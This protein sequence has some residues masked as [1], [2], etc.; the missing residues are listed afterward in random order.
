MSDVLVLIG[1]GQQAAYL[2]DQIHDMLDQGLL[3]HDHYF[4]REGMTEWRPLAEFPER[5]TR[6]VV[7][8]RRGE[9]PV[10]ESVTPA[11][12]TTMP[13]RNVTQQVGPVRYNAPTPVAEE[14]EPRY[15]LLLLRLAAIIID[16]A[17]AFGP[18]IFMILLM[19]VVLGGKITRDPANDTLISMI[20]LYWI[21]LLIV[22]PIMLAAKGQTI[23]KKVMGLRIVSARTG[24][25]A[26]FF[27]TV[28]VRTLTN[29]FFGLIPICLLFHWM[30]FS[31]L[32]WI[33]LY[34]IIDVLP[35]FY[36]DRCIHDYVAGT[37]VAR[38]RGY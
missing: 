10:R 23:G 21:G 33:C 9:E 11:P 19:G 28:V 3:T 26:G 4:W 15:I 34:A 6:A 5:V 17:G 7:P 13:P 37:D 8:P 36:D 38:R 22:Q 32:P 24:Y 14:H 16:M 30:P 18:L 31:W 35:I 2:V 25:S 1:E 20:G 12:R 29:G 27:R